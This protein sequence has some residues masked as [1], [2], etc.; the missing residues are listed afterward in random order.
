MTILDAT[1]RVRGLNQSSSYFDLMEL[2]IATLAVLF[3]SLGLTYAELNA[4]AAF[5]AWNKVKADRPDDPKLK[6]ASSELFEQVLLEL[7]TW[8]RELEGVH[9]NIRKSCGEVVEFLESVEKLATSS[10]SK[11]SGGPPPSGSRSSGSTPS[12]PST[13]Y[14]T[15]SVG[16]LSSGKKG[17][18]LN[19][20]EQSFDAQPIT[21]GHQP[22]PSSSLVPSGNSPRFHSNNRKIMPI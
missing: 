16:P 20:D 2:K 10:Y 6:S 18:R 3:G 4:R 14:S 22:P 13:D 12:S 11:G 15:G 5:D 8:E 7:V 9:R 1:P 21:Q 17:Q 19:S